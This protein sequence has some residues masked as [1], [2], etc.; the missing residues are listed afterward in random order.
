MIEA[1]YYTISINGQEAVDRA[2]TLIGN[3]CY[4]PIGKWQLEIVIDEDGRFNGLSNKWVDL[5]YIHENEI[6]DAKAKLKEL[7]FCGTALLV[8]EHINGCFAITL[9]ET[10]FTL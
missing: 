5:S 4:L 6:A 2:R 1:V 9:K 8:K 3:K 7:G 10:I